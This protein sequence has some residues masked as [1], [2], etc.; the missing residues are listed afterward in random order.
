MDT[1]SSGG[2]ITGEE[3]YQMAREYKHSYMQGCDVFFRVGK[4]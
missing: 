4:K 2:A 1:K 3:F